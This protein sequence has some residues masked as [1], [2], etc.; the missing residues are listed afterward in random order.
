M[1]TGLT[2]VANGDY[3]TFNFAWGIN[4][5]N[6][7]VV[8]AL[9]ADNPGLDE[10]VEF[11]YFPTVTVTSSGGG[12]GGPTQVDYINLTTNL[13]DYINEATNYNSITIEDGQLV[14]KDLLETIGS[15]MRVRISMTL[16]LSRHCR[17]V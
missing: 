12:G 10:R 3:F 13:R 5:N 2:P 6:K 8:F 14:F 4:Q 17:T 9:P 11:I 1:V 16:S 15:V 7:N